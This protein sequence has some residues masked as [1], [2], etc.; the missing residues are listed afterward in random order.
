MKG[1]AIMV[2]YVIQLYLR[3]CGKT[4]DDLTK[5]LVNSYNQLYM[6]GWGRES[7]CVLGWSKREPD[8]C[9]L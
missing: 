7:L 9:L 6:R 8:P 4:S 2:H 5:I 1:S 3:L